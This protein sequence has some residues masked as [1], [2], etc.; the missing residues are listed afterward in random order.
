MGNGRRIGGEASAQGGEIGQALGGEVDRQALGEFGLAAP[1]M[2]E[3]EEID[4]DAA[5]LSLG[6]RG[7]QGLE[8]VPVGWAWEEAVA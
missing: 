8:G 5:G 7:T 2:S 6:K 3:R 1:V 4:G